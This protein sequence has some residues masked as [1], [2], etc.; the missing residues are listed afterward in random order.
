ML[1]PVGFGRFDA[2]DCSQVKIPKGTSG[3]RPG[4]IAIP[5]EEALFHIIGHVLEVSLPILRLIGRGFVGRIMGDVVGNLFIF[6]LLAV[7]LSVN[8]SINGQ[9][10]G[11]SW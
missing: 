2:W 5:A 4:G 8:D 6:K 7:E 11:Q 1:F 10:S 9:V 3:G